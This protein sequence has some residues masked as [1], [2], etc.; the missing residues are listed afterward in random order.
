MFFICNKLQ[1]PY[2]LIH[3]NR[4]HK[5]I[6]VIVNL[7]RSLTLFDKL[8]NA[9]AQEV[10]RDHITNWGRLGASQGKVKLGF[11]VSLSWKTTCFDVVEFDCVLLLQLKHF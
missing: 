10:L 1:N 5:S 7:L 6:T 4:R 9:K 11:R 8:S 3:I 2:K